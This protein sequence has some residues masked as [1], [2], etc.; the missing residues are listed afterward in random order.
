MLRARLLQLIRKLGLSHALDLL[1]FRVKQVRN[2]GANRA[3]KRANPDF[4]LPPDYLLYESFQI[5]YA[6]Y[7]RTGLEAAKW[8]YDHFKAHTETL[9]SPTIL[10]WGCGPGRILRH[11]PA[12]FGSGATGIGLD[13]N[14]ASIN[15]CSNVLSKLPGGTIRVNQS[16]L[17]PPL[18]LE[19][20]SIDLIYGISILTHLSEPAHNAWIS[21]L[22]RV[23]RPGGMALLTTHGPG[24]RVK[25]TDAERKKYDQNE[26]IIRGQVQEGHRVFTAYHPPQK[27]RELFAPVAEI[28]TYVEGQPK[29]W[30]IEQDVWVVKK[31]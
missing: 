26:L 27:M 20:A 14:V 25:L 9:D 30:G 28:L 17:S 8:I 10:D 21:E 7:Q 1:R 4:P 13:P 24:Y 6:A 18:P 2:Y 3:F 19:A 23:L 16:R 29:N 12:V 11:L 15:W 5:N 31:R 22:M